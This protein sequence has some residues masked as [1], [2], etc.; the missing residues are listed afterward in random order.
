MPVSCSLLKLSTS[1]SLLL[2]L[3]SL[4]E[5]YYYSQ[6]HR[7]RSTKFPN[8]KELNRTCCTPRFLAM[9]AWEIQCFKLLHRTWLL[10]KILDHLFFALFCLLNKSCQGSFSTS[11]R[12]IAW[13]AEQWEGFGGVCCFRLPPWRLALCH[14]SNSILK[15]V[16]SLL[17]CLDCPC[18]CLT[19]YFLHVSDYFHIM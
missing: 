16:N 13:N 7:L 3:C 9:H 4:P 17:S 18:Q 14:D 11:I 19:F 1:V 12:T 10:H 2:I 8:P 15:T 6:S 5:R